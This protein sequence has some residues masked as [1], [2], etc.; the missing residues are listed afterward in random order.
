MHTYRNNTADTAPSHRDARPILP[1]NRRIGQTGGVT[2][3]RHHSGR[4][5][6]IVYCRNCLLLPV[7]TVRVFAGP[8]EQ[9]NGSPLK[10]EIAA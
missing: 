3:A 6:L 4:R 2:T 1:E 8:H 7:S 5:A 9:P 10:T